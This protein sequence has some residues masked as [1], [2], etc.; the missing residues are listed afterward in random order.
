MSQRQS[1]PKNQSKNQSK[2][3]A[4]QNASLEER[5]SHL[6]DSYWCWLWSEPLQGY[7]CIVDYNLQGTEPLEQAIAHFENMYP[8]R[9]FRI[10]KNNVTVYVKPTKPIG[11]QQ[12][13]LF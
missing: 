3:S 11:A 10:D 8:D 7:V 9:L 1:R 13:S 4:R 5:K 6:T 2:K 12:L